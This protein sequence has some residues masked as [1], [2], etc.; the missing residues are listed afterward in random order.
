VVK[1]LRLGALQTADH[2]GALYS[3][4]SFQGDL[5]FGQMMKE[6]G[7]EV[8]PLLSLSQVRLGNAT[9]APGLL[10]FP[11][12]RGPGQV[13]LYGKAQTNQMAACT[14]A[15]DVA[16]LSWAEKNARKL[17]PAG[18]TLNQVVRLLRELY[19][20]PEVLAAGR[21]AD[22]TVLIGRELYRQCLA[23]LGEP[24]YYFLEVESILPTL[25][26]ED[27]ENS[28]SILFQL[29]TD[30]RLRRAMEDDVLNPGT[31]LKAQL[32]FAPDSKGRHVP[33]TLEEDGMLRGA[34]MGGQAMEFSGRPEDV[35]RCVE[36]RELDLSAAPKDYEGFYHYVQSAELGSTL[37]SSRSAIS[38]TALRRTKPWAS[39]CA[40]GW[41]RGRSTPLPSPALCRAPL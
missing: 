22:Q 12:T 34:A 11:D 17:L 28:E 36:Q 40:S 27:L 33:L 10:C 30:S 15:F 7:A 16:R 1:A 38:S 14:P 9:F 37:P 21:Y 4:Q 31:S 23:P 19:T 5:L 25:V 35:V 26:R 20:R 32:F 39:A 6:E 8:I 29:L 41:S 18:E 3:P 24:S 2:H 13:Q